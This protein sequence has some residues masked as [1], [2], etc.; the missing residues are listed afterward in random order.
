MSQLNWFQSPQWG[1]NS[2]ADI[3]DVGTITN[4]FQSPQWGDN[5][6]ESFMG[7]CSEVGVFQSPQWGDNSKVKTAKKSTIGFQCFSPR[8]GGRKWYSVAFTH[9]YLY[10]GNRIP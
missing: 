3:E 1:D 7:I 9:R 5:S 8:I 2:K 6:K 10:S 4:K